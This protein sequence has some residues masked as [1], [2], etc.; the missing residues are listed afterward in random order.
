VKLLRSGAKY[1]SLFLYFVVD[2]LVYHSTLNGSQC[3]FIQTSEVG[4]DSK[5]VSKFVE[6]FVITP[7]SRG[8]D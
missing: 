7:P 6:K 1:G 8:D 5:N 3:K 2:G 4:H